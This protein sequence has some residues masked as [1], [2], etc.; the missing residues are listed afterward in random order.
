MSGLESLTVHAYAAVDGRHLTRLPYASASWSDSINEPGQM[1]VDM[2]MSSLSHRLTVDGQSIRA[3][4]R[5]WRAILAVQRGMHVLHAGPVTGRKWDAANRKLSFTCGGGWTLLGKRLVLNHKLDASFQDGEILIDEDHPAGDWALKLK[6][7]YRDIAR[8]IIAETLEWGPLPFALPPV[9]GG[10]YTR[11]YGGWDLATCADRID[12]LSNLAIG[13]EFRFTPRIDDTGSLSFLL[14]AGT[15]LVDHEYDLDA[16]IP[17]QRVALGSID[18]DGAPMTCEVW[19]AGGKDN[20]KT[21]MARAQLPDQYRDP[22]LPVMQTSNTSHTTVSKVDTL[23]AYARAQCA[24]GAWPDETFALTLGEE[25]DPHVGDHLAVRVD[26]DYLGLTRLELKVTD[27][28]AR[29]DSD[30]VTV[31]CRE[32]SQP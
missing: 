28:S 27:V 22:G 1:S 32:R 29:S 19:A 4:L 14:E 6:G 20:D 8:G 17:G 31:Q 18:E 5:P 26:D 16:T 21:V 10:A 3:V 25:F 30:W 23:R 7:S 11:T 15:E 13:H 12:D 2:T 24:L 9:E